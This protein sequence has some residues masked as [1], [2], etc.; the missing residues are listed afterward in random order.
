[1]PERVVFKFPVQF[2]GGFGPVEMHDG[3]EVVH[4]DSQY[5]GVY[6]WAICDLDAPLVMRRLGYFATGAEVPADAT[7][8][9]TAKQD[10]GALIWHVFE[11][12]D[13]DA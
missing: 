5:R 3:A 7:Y 4:V 13:R 6:V 8:L 12:G 10:G 2:F 9:G 1:M 11:N